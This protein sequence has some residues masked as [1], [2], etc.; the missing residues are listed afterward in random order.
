M[1][2]SRQKVH[3][4]KR[5]V[6]LGTITLSSAGITTQGYSFQLDE[7]PNYTEFT[8]LYDQYKLSAVAIKF[9]SNARY[10]TVQSNNNKEIIGILGLPQ[11]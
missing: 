1:T 11:L 10:I 9:I 6:D 3:F 4:F 8:A 5:H 2:P 7:V